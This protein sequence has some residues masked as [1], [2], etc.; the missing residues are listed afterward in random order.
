M[1][2]EA[3]RD[4]IGPRTLRDMMRAAS[5]HPESRWCVTLVGDDGTAVAHGC[6]R[7]RQPGTRHPTAGTASTR[8][9]A[10]AQFLA[11]LKISF[12]PIARGSCDHRHAGPATGPAGSSGT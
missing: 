9:A 10:L 8:A 3:G 2:G 5:R 1:P 12:E 7:G 4:I 11:R 6:A